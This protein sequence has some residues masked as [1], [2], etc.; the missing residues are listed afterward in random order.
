MIRGDIVSILRKIFVLLMVLSFLCLPAFAEEGEHDGY[1]IK[2]RDS[3]KLEVV[4]EIPIM[5]FGDTSN[6]EYIEPDYY[7]ELFGSEPTWNQP[8]IQGKMWNVE[9]INVPAFW[10]AGVYGNGAKIAVIDSG[11]TVDD[12]ISHAVE[13][14]VTCVSGEPLTNGGDISGH[15]TNISKI[16]ATSWGVNTVT[17]IAP[18][19]KIRSYKCCKMVNGDSKV[20]S[21]AAISA[22][23]MAVKDGCKI[24][25]MS[26]G[27]PS[28]SAS[29]ETAINNA[30]A[31]GIIL[32]ASVGN[33]GDTTLNYPAAYSSVIG[34]GSVNHRNLRSFFSVYNSSVF[35]V[36]P[37]EMIASE[38][39]DNEDGS[40][41]ITRISGTSF[42][43]PTVA[44]MAA[45]CL[46]MKPDLN[47]T[48]FEKLIAE[49]STDLG[50]TG[51]DNYYGYGLINGEKLLKS[52][53]VTPT[54][55]LEN[56]KTECTV[57]V[58]GVKNDDAGIVFFQTEN[59]VKN[60]EFTAKDGLVTVTF[61][62]VIP[63][64]DRVFVW[65]SNLSPIKRID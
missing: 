53:F 36:A 31:K 33:N 58:E 41:G 56:G 22:L 9:N 65:G 24:V 29:L 14:A 63:V 37:G 61:S 59:G 60:G 13:S 45:L 4:S 62:G 47:H 5:L 3:D 17:G 50:E 20:V 64:P 1:I 40:F 27:G 30:A 16:I 49:T 34:V 38:V 2:Y 18:E 57:Y 7:Y 48:G 11:V 52:L 44:A 42:S 46:S 51:R 54:K 35:V 10:N 26:F 28:N 6:I 8:Y 12:T 15:G 55:K 19:V 43:A 39:K 21:S 23:D 32:V 25:N